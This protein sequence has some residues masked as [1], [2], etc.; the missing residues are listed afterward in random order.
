[1][2]KAKTHGK[3]FALAFVGALVLGLA[4]IALQFSR[5]QTAGG[6]KPLQLSSI[7]SVSSSNPAGNYY[8]STTNPAEIWND[9]NGISIWTGNFPTPYTECGHLGMAWNLSKT[10]DASQTNIWESRSVCNGYIAVGIADKVEEQTLTV[11]GVT[12]DGKTLSNF[13]INVPAITG[14]SLGNWKLYVDDTGATYYCRADHSFASNR[15]PNDCDLTITGALTAAHLAR[16]GNAPVCGNNICQNG[17]TYASCSADCPPP[18]PTCTLTLNDNKTTY[19]SNSTE[20]VNY[21][22]TCLSATSVAVQV[23]KPDGTAT[24]YNTS[25]NITTSTMGFGTSNLTAGNYTL[26]ICVNDNTC[27]SPS[28]FV[29]VPFAVTAPVVTSCAGMNLSTNKTSYSGGEGVTLN[30]SCASPT[31][32]TLSSLTV[33]VIAPNGDANSAVNVTTITPPVG[34][35]AVTLPATYV[36]PYSYFTAAGSY[37]IRTCMNG[38][39]TT[40]GLNSTFANFTS[41]TTTVPTT[42]NSPIGYWKFDGNGTNEVVGG[43]AAAIVGSAQF[44]ST[45]G[46]FGGYAYIPSIGNYFKIPY[47]SIFDLPDSFTIQFWF[48]QRANQSANQNLIYKGA[49]PNNYNFNISRWLWNEYNQGPVIA[50]HTAANTGYWTQPSNPNQLSHNEWHSVVFTKSPTYHAYYL[51]GTLIGSKNVGP[52]SSDSADY[53]GPAKTPHNDIVIGDTAVDTDMDDLKIYNRALSAAEVSAIG[54]FPTLTAPTAPSGL[55][56]TVISNGTVVNLSWTDNSGNETGFRVYRR[57]TAP[58]LTEWIQDGT[59]PPGVGSY[60]STPSHAGTFEYKVVA[61]LTGGSANLESA[62]SNTVSAVTTGSAATTTATIGAG[63]P[64]PAN[65]TES[66]VWAQVDVATGQILSTAI[67]TRSVCGINGEY[68]GYVPPATFA[69]G[70]TWW[71]TSKRYIWQM[72][73]QAGYGTGTFNFNTYIFTV[74]GGTIYNGVFTPTATT[75]PT[76]TTPTPPTVSDTITPIT[77]IPTPIP[78][79]TTT[80]APKSCTN[81]E[82][83]AS[84]SWCNN[85]SMCYYPDSQLTCVAWP[86]PTAGFA[87]PAMGAV[88]C[89]A[90]TSV[91]NPTDANCVAPGQ[92]VPYVT[93]KWCM[94]GQ[95]Y[96]SSD[97]KSMTCVKW[98]ESAPSGYSSCRPDDTSCIPEGEYGSSSGWCTNAMKCYQKAT[99]TDPKNDVYCA[100]MPYSTMASSDSVTCPSGY[101]VCSATDTTCKQKGDKWTDA[102]SGYY[103]NNSQKCTLSSGGGLCVG[104]NEACPAGTKYCSSGD[105]YCIEPGEYKTLGSGTTGGYWCGGGSGMTFYSSSK[106]YCEPKKVGAT[107]ADT[108]WTSADVKAILNKLGAGWGICRPGDSNCIEPGKTGPSSGWCGWMQPGNYMSPSSNG[109]GTRTCPSL[110]EVAAP[111]PVTPVIPT[112][113]TAETPTATPVVKPAVPP[114]PQYRECAAGEIPNVANNCVTPRYRWNMEAKVF[115]KCAGNEAAVY[116]AVST[117]TS[118]ATVTNGPKQR[119]TNCEPINLEIEKE[120]RTERYMVHPPEKDGEWYTPPWD[121]ASK[122]QQYNAGTDQF[123][124]CSLN[125]NAS[126]TVAMPNAA[127]CMPVPEIDRGWMLKKSRAEYKMYLMYKNQGGLSATPAVQLPGEPTKGPNLS[128]FILKPVTPQIQIPQTQCKGYLFSVRQGLN[129]DK[130]FWK[131]LNRQIGNVP[132]D[133]PDLEDFNKLLKDSKDIIV[134]AEKL[135]KGANCGAQNV[136]DLKVKLDILHSELFPQLSSYMPG[137]QDYVEVGQCKN[138]LKDKQAQLAKLMKNGLDAELKREMQ[139]LTAA[140]DAKFKELSDNTDD[141]EYDARF[142]C[143][144]FRDEVESQIAPLLRLG[145]KEINAIIEKIVSQ[146]FQPVIEQLTAQYEER[147]KKIDELLVQVAELHKSIEAVSKFAAQMSERIAV[148]YSAMT[149]IPEKFAEQKAQI[150]AA[151]DKLMPR[152]QT[153]VALIKEKNCVR[154]IDRENLLQALANAGSVNWIGERADEVDKRITVFVNACSSNDVSP[155]DIATLGESINT[156]ASQ[157]LQDSYVQRLTRFAD[158]PTDTYYYGPMQ[159]SCYTQGRPGEN[160]LKQDALLMILRS[161]GAP[162][163]EI[164]GDCGAVQ[165][166]RGVS[167]YASCAVKYALKNG[168]KFEGLMSDPVDRVEIA[169]WLSQLG[170]VK[171]RG[172]AEDLKPYTDINGLDKNEREAVANAVRNEVMVGNVS[173]GIGIFRPNSSLARADLAV[174]LQKLG[175]AKCSK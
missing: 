23:V 115:E 44:K 141:F 42:S 92:A 81:G 166:V 172:S 22:Y 16:A 54:G 98:G 150:Q 56:S 69:T 155:A 175:G 151:K 95:S 85:G 65:S 25:T 149:Q 21:T 18:P 77:I 29:S 113:P 170:V 30:Y 8:R 103:C 68:H 49:A 173:D 163:S 31:N 83:C 167:S 120:W 70:S 107:M 129:G 19:V 48:R 114:A 89:P 35:T 97:G 2:R 36:I 171:E 108:M 110:D 45:G 88:S 121:A 168:V 62:P 137:I 39:C 138:A 10:T 41:S 132:E 119:Y 154:G 17:E 104:W 9:N 51:D 148:S 66:G 117:V 20:F 106:A 24:I 79:P 160:A 12:A 142:E 1:M 100:K 26:R 73:G 94:Q 125:G 78:I 131:D 116:T 50:G 67:C 130:A 133:Y 61:Y 33:Q 136:S 13:Q 60:T 15:Y 72:P 43:P 6:I 58:N 7:T 169:Q 93:G 101:S 76:P 86:T 53:G 57:I 139:D 28:S 105:Q 37:L 152:I 165:G 134:A 38:N 109:V 90:G 91:C 96:Y 135:A 118:T 82:K 40:G 55:T 84:G 14:T 164:I 47:N 27:S 112:T 126:A 87:T 75:T 174:I 64:E 52:G 71:P 127:P 63:A 11:S 124:E 157:N 153:A 147:G 74:T 5:A 159:A 158:V 161:S 80:T 59:T 99:D 140:I 128:D 156:A 144:Q 123:E 146:K 102:N 145:D 143:Q 34:G 46:K 122:M 4:V 111:M 32:G 3:L 162:E